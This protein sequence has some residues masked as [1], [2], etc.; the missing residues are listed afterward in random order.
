MSNLLNNDR[1]LILPFDGDQDTRQ[2]ILEEL[3]EVGENGCDKE[4]GEWLRDSLMTSNLD[5]LVVP[6]VSLSP[7]L[8]RCVHAELPFFRTIVENSPD[9]ALV[10]AID[11]LKDDLNH[12]MDTARLQERLRILRRR[13]ALL[14][15]IADIFGLWP[16]E[17]ITGVLSQFADGVLSATVSHLL[18][19]SAEKGEIE[20][21]DDF[22]PEDKCGFFLIAMGKYGARELNYSSDIDL[23]ALYDPE[24]IR[25]TGKRQPQQVFVKLMRGLV[26]ILQDMTKDGYVYRVDLRLRPDPSATPIVMPIGS[27]LSYYQTRGANWE[28]AAM[29]KAR[30][31]AGDVALGRHFIGQ[32]SDFVWR[33]DIDFWSQ[34]QIGAIK[35]QINEQKGGSDIG[36]LG[37]N[38]KTGSGGIRE[39]EFFA[40]THQLVYGGKDSY[41]RNSR[42]LEVL[43]TLSEADLVG[44]NVADELTEAYEFL[45][46]LEHRLQMVD[47][48]QTQ[49]L[50]S[51]TAEMERIANFM[52]YQNLEIFEAGVLHQLNIVSA[53]YHKFFGDRSSVRAAESSRQECDRQV[54]SLGDVESLGF[55]DAGKISAIFDCWQ[56]GELPLASD[57]ECKTMFIGLLPDIVEYCTTSANP[58]EAVIFVDHF[59]R[60]FPPRLTELSLLNSNQDLLHLVIRLAAL[61]PAIAH[62]ICAYPS[63]LQGAVARSFFD[64][65]P[66]YRIV[67]AELDATLPTQI[68]AGDPLSDLSSFIEELRFRVKTNLALGNIDAHEAGR[69]LSNLSDVLISRLSV[70]LGQSILD[71][72]P[73][74][75]SKFAILAYG[76]YGRQERMPGSPSNIL[77]LHDEDPDTAAA[78]EKFCHHLVGTLSTPGTVAEFLQLNQEPTPLN[79]DQLLLDLPT[80]LQTCSAQSSPLAGLALNDA[81]IV[82]SGGGFGK[83]AMDAISTHLAESPFDKL[84]YLTTLACAPNAEDKAD[85]AQ[86]PIGLRLGKLMD[87]L[88]KLIA[89]LPG[90]L[91]AATAGPDPEIF[92]QVANSFG[93]QGVQI[94]G[95]EIKRILEMRATVYRCLYFHTVC[96]GRQDAEPSWTDETK[97]KF[98]ELLSLSDASEFGDKLSTFEMFQ[99]RLLDNLAPQQN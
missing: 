56:K 91:S 36:F 57:E 37:H 64:A 65:L 43:H 10:E 45:R 8:R 16:L 89:I 39:V 54:V 23:I 75:L 46:R 6:I 21:W 98:A 94:D 2:A 20:I 83:V 27:A 55:Q 96:F 78:L 81:R 53:H 73:L 1:I 52:G 40:Q 74:D 14:V 26:S 92:Q 41:L 79:S 61:S 69:N 22:F 67:S 38:V 30:P 48:Q 33:P 4:T 76:G 59:F 90:H 93:E 86:R 29:I 18:R 95:A 49:T 19:L 24:K 71:T 77:F 32:L 9:D 82:Y 88:D 13:I 87:G 17:K 66:D 42:T 51:N 44:E 60:H 70:R 99:D 47:D 31:A 25:D 80:F 3:R 85:Q 62:S 35:E 15:A 12:E 7:F 50:P 72:K 58:D 97:S 5:Q 84:A 34:R 68:T 11:E 63:V 28:R